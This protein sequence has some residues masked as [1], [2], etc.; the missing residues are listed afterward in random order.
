M[1]TQTDTPIVESKPVG[2]TRLAASLWA[3]FAV[4]FINSVAT[5]IAYNGVFFITDKAYGF[6][7]QH[8]L[9]YGLMMG[10]TY[11][12]GALAAGPGIRA[13]RARFPSLTTRGVLIAVMFL[14]TALYL[15]PVIAWFAAPAASR[16]SSQWAM[17]AF[18]ACYSTLC[19][20]LWPI[21]ESFLSGGRTDHSLRA[22]TGKFNVCWSSALV[23]A[24]LIVSQAPGAIRALTG[25]TDAA[26]D[27]AA[28]GLTTLDATVSTLAIGALLHLIAIFTITALPREPGAHV[29]ETHTYPPNYPR[30]LAVHRA[31]LPASYM[32]MYVMLPLMPSLF[33]TVGITSTATASGL[34]ATWLAARIVMFFTLDRWHG[35]HGKWIT[36]VSGAI[37]MLAGFTLCIASGSLGDSLGL[38]ALISGL[39]IFGAGVAAIYSA[40]LYYALEVGAAAVDAGGMHEALIGVGYTVGPAL[41]LGALGLTPHAEPGSSAQVLSLVGLVALG[42]LAGISLAVTA[43]VRASSRLE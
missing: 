38:A 27:I 29:H 14:A 23:V 31:L 16:L 41:G 15:L 6:S 3:V 8:N 17:W 13:L 10:V 1:S 18:M 26:P 43:G 33:K 4:T 42:S 40:A 5:G 34:T 36:A 37:G 20:V 39:A 11:I 21:V 30:L 25:A 2:S 24:M 12:V 19:G 35:W 9:L 22:A 28:H 7:R 32:V